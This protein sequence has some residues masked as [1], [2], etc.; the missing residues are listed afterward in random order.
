MSQCP[1][2]L[3]AVCADRDLTKPAP[4][5][6]SNHKKQRTRIRRRPPQSKP[7][8]D[9][10][11]DELATLK[12]LAAEVTINTVENE[13]DV[14]SDSIVD[15]PPPS[16]AES[17]VFQHKSA[18]TYLDLLVHLFRDENHYVVITHL[19]DLFQLYYGQPPSLPRL[20]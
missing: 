17:F 15:P 20:P 6:S 4:L 16:Q 2:V 9:S 13:S 10:P 7:T 18:V 3:C 11:G 12:A 5:S 8:I 14:G 1:F 19:L